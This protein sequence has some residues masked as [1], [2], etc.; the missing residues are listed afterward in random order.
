MPR[1]CRGIISIALS[2]QSLFEVY[3]TRCLIQ[4]ERSNV[5]V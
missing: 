1:I 4:C 3:R 2:K 5:A